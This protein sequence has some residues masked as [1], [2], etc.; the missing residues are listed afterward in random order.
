MQDLASKIFYPPG[1]PPVSLT[2]NFNNF[3]LL[4]ASQASFGCGWFPNPL[5]AWNGSDCSQVPDIPAIEAPLRMEFNFLAWSL[6]NTSGELVFP[7]FRPVRD[8]SGEVEEVRQATPS[9]LWLAPS[10]LRDLFRRLYMPYRF[11]FLFL[12]GSR[13]TFRNFFQSLSFRPNQASPRPPSRG[14]QEW[15]T[16]GAS[17]DGNRRVSA[18]RPA[19]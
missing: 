8:V 3:N 10:G 1:H 12:K 11:K 17:T 7:P 19:P 16:P 15:G 14:R 5:W 9:G 4:R 13:A 18:R 6:A 2:R